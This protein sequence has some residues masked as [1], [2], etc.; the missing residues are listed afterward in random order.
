MHL[1][2]VSNI[3]IIDQ[4]ARY[5]TFKQECIKNGKQEPKADGVLIFDEVKVACQLMWNS[6]N[7]Q[8][9]GLAMTS[10]DLASLNDI[11]KMLQ[12]PAANQA[13]YIL[14]FLWRDLTSNYDIV[15]LFCFNGK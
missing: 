14:Q 2:G 4:V 3:C 9:M 15:G 5:V 6:R 12:D 13:S 7:Q 1:P 11:Y 10:Q 8:L